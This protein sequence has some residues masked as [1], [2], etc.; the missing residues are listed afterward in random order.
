MSER[1]FERANRQDGA[2]GSLARHTRP[3]DGVADLGMVRP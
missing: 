1:V 3:A 2:E